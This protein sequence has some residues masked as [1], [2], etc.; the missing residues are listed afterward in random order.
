M[1]DSEKPDLPTAT[2]LHVTP[3]YGF[4][5]NVHVGADALAANLAALLFAL[6]P[7]RWEKGPPADFIVR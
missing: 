3:P 4:R 6:S 5:V 7:A 2:D 1:S